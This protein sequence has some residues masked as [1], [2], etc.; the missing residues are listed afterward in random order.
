M[1]DPQ[2]DVRG[3]TITSTYSHSG[4][5]GHG[6]DKWLLTLTIEVGRETTPSSIHARLT[7]TAEK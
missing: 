7:A 1:P 5:L 4:G 3:V 6:A 2:G